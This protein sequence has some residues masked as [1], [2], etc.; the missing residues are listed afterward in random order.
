MS[1]ID[2]ATITPGRR[3]LITFTIML[4]TIV[5]AVDTTIAV[6]ALPHMQGSMSATTDQIAWVLTSYIVASAIMTPPTG[7]LAARLG[8]R[9]LFATMVGG[10]TLTSML[11]GAA[12]SL[13]QI[14]LFRILQGAFGA[15]LIPLSQ[16]VLL[17]INPRERHGQAIAMWGLGV[18]VGP[19]IGPTLG[20][21]LTEYFSWR[22]VFYVN[23]P[24]GALA[25][26]GILAF[27]PET[28]RIRRRFDWFGFA[29]LSLAIGSLQMMLDRGESQDWFSS[30][31]IVLEAVMAGL[32]LYLFLV[33]MFTADE[34]F[35]EPALFRDRN[36]AAGLVFMTV[37]GMVLFSSLTLLPTFLQNVLGYPVLDAG[38]ILA[39]RGF[40]TG[41]AMFLVGRLL[42]R[43]DARWFIFIGLALTAASLWEMSQF[44][45][46]VTMQRFIL[47]SIAQGFGLGFVFVPLSTIAFSTMD[48][49]LRS[50]GTAMFSLLRNI[51]SS[52]GISLVVSLLAQNMQRAHAGLAGIMSPFR[53]TMNAPFLPQTWNWH[54]PTGVMA[55]NGEI[56]KQAVMVAYLNDFLMLV[57]LS[58]IPMVLLPLMRGTRASA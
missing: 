8:R 21:Y 57:V 3:A 23:L 46:D 51:G 16:A 30:P 18:M 25:L 5:Y 31:E 29:L 9:R 32:C 47:V 50:E 22:W 28:D 58:L 15:G 20:G 27:V 2:P 33:H 26:A 41:L 55:L 17:D 43:F 42:A 24:V 13:E 40:G 48:P 1:P 53:D 35:I 10:F 54:L 49:R 56:A 44:T 37:I 34:P 11:C 38:F 6:V 36:F 52:I 7:F 19:I 39:P 12:T 14:V 45:V 4:A